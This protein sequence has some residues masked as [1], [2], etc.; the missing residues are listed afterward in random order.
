MSN[1]N[2]GAGGNLGTAMLDIATTGAGVSANFPPLA[3]PA[4]ITEMMQRENDDLRLRNQEL[5]A[6]EQIAKEANDAMRAERDRLQAQIENLLKPQRDQAIARAEAAEALCAELR[7]KL[8]EI[9]S[10]LSGDSVLD[11]LAEQALRTAAKTPG[12]MGEEVARLKALVNANQNQAAGDMANALCEA[13][14][15]ANSIWRSEYKNDAPNWQPLGTVVGV[16]SQIDNMYAG[17]REQRNAL[18]QQL[19][20]LEKTCKERLKRI[21]DLQHAAM[22]DAT[23]IDALRAR[24]AELEID[25][26]TEREVFRSDLAKAEARK[27]RLVAA[28]NVLREW[29][30]DNFDCVGAKADVRA[31]DAAL[32]DNGGATAA[33][34][35]T[36]APQTNVISLADGS[37]AGIR[38]L[39]DAP[40]PPT[41]TWAISF[42]P[43]EAQ[44][45]ILGTIGPTGE[46]EIRSTADKIT[47]AY[48][49]S[50]GLLWFA[51][52]LLEILRLR[53]NLGGDVSKSSTRP[54]DLS[55][56]G[57]GIDGMRYDRGQLV[58]RLET[59]AAELRDDGEDRDLWHANV[60]EQAAAQLGAGIDTPHPD[61]AR[62]AFEF[63]PHSDQR[64]PKFYLLARCYSRDFAIWWNPQSKGYTSNLSR[65][66]L[67]SKAEAKQIEGG[68][69][70]DHVAIPE[71]VALGLEWSRAVDVSAALNAAMQAAKEGGR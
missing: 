57:A 62:P 35:S 32:A 44:P 12:E 40:Q 36:P 60:I 11:S 15:L 14:R 23:T 66:G 53:E 26:E 43:A 9:G 17:V 67:Y 47:A 30:A 65:A 18:R 27:E 54:A 3:T 20:E 51:P 68:T 58:V 48:K 64:E 42:S 41:E 13:S 21:D 61:S 50:P 49:S 34:V 5:R 55:K 56:N 19:A 29:V 59:I 37:P 33:N 39:K 52:L 28:G 22:S 70:G 2:T 45:E 71:G 10:A 8:E 31:W 1:N 6:R 63:I 25:N 16:I 46:V 4:R 38:W 69:H 24:V 7:D